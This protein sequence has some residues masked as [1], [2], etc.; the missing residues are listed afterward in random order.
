MIK[1]NSFGDKVLV[2]DGHQNGDVII[3]DSSFQALQEIIA[4]NNE[5]KDE[6]NLDK[7]KK[8]QLRKRNFFKANQKAMPMYRQLISDKQYAAAK[9]FF[10]IL[11]NMDFQ[12][13]VAASY[14]VLMEQCGISK[15]TT[16]RGIKYLRNNEYL[17]IEK[18]GNSNVYFINPLIAEKGSQSSLFNKFTGNI[19]FSKKE[20][21]K[22]IRKSRPTIIR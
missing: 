15:P 16:S 12:N 7:K 3:S 14:E 4:E 19:L 2:A 17:T 11:E 8:D 20:N 5:M 6:K 9:I 10:F 22:T 1:R 13:C 18:I 21:A